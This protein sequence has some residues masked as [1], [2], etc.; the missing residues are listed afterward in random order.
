[1]FL[2]FQACEKALKQ[3]ML[4]RHDVGRLNM[5]ST[6]DLCRQVK[7]EHVLMLQQVR[8]WPLFKTQLRIL[9]F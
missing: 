5:L 7:W 6:H 3:D 9:T 4:S 1:M 8:F 2:R